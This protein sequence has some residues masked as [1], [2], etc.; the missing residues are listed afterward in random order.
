MLSDLILMLENVS[1]EYPCSSTR[2]EMFCDLLFPYRF[3]NRRYTAVHPLSLQVRRGECLGIMGVNGSGKSTL[4]QMIA[5]T[6]HPTSGQIWADGKI[7]SLLELGSWINAT[8][9]GR[10]NIYTAG[11]IRGLT[12]KQIDEQLPEIIEFSEIGEFIDQPVSTYSTGMVMRLA[13]SAC[14][15]METDILLLDEVFAVGDARFAQKCIAFLR[16]YIRSRTVL[17]VSHDVNIITM[18]CSRAILL[19]HGRLIADGSPR[20]ISERYLEL[21]YGEKQN[22]EVH[23]VETAE[24][25][26]DC[27]KGEEIAVLPFDSSTRA[28]GEGGAVI[29]SAQ[30]LAADG[31]PLNSVRGGESVRLAIRARALKQLELPATGFIVR[32]PD[33]QHLFGDTGTPGAIPQLPEGGVMETVFDFVLPRLA[34]GNYSIGISVST[35][36]L[37]EHHIQIWNHNALQFQVQSGLPLQG[38]LIGLPMRS[39]TISECK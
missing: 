21:C 5:G 32:A 3:K 7:A 19:D 24:I 8:E 34:N 9:T 30:F 38:V 28:F 35:G 14:I 37:D 22:V 12:K 6:V 29:E 27:R 36:R 2:R 16:E 26:E 17:L 13:F 33:G 1:K 23:G 39:I 31:T 4:L 10:E 15:K 25:P 20:V 11:Y 18:L